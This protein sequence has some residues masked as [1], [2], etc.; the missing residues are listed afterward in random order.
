[1]AGDCDYLVGYVARQGPSDDLTWSG[2]RKGHGSLLSSQRALT[3]LH[4][5]LFLVLCC[6]FFSYGVPI[7]EGMSNAGHK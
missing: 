3:L 1:M 4:S 7:V 6:Y 2:L 5:D